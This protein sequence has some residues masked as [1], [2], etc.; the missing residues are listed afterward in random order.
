[1][2]K[3]EHLDIFDPL[4]GL[5]ALWVFAG[6]LLLRTTG[7]SSHAEIAVD[8]FMFV[9]G[10]LM[11]HIWS[12]DRPLEINWP[13]VRAF[14]I[15][16]FWRIAPVYYILLLYAMVFHNLLNDQ[17]YQTALVFPPPWSSSPPVLNGGGWMALPTTAIT[18]LTL[19]FGMIP[20]QSEATALPD[21]SIGLEV[22]FYAAFPLLLLAYRRINLIVVVVGA[23]LISA[24]TARLF[25]LYLVDGL[26]GRFPEPSFLGFKLQIFVLGS[27]AAILYY[28][29]RPLTKR[30]AL[31]GGALILIS[32]SRFPV[33]LALLV[34]CA[35]VLCASLLPIITKRV[36]TSKIAI[37][38]GDTSYSVYLVHNLILTPV[39]FWLSQ[40]QFFV[41]MTVLSRFALSFAIIAPAVYLISYIILITI[42]RP[43]IKIGRQL[44]RPFG[45]TANAG[46]GVA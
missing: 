1:M 30:M 35:L 21:W 40:Q 8:I 44:S 19:V 42:E 34:A 17:T 38:L 16:R 12:T 43:C 7:I 2:Q 24:L 15:R 41:H 4:R 11:F 25:G 46:I 13:T 26:L 29:D 39:C 6:H 27:I 18:H 5:M 23:L 3:T 9:S 33:R 37:F 31:I 14:Y 32:E 10:F 22:Q 45:G 36:I 28:D 20:S